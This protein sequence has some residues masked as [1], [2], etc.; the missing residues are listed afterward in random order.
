MKTKKPIWAEI[1]NE[2]QDSHIR[3]IDAYLT[4]DEGEKGMY[5]K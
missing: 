2:F 3:H 5:N 1:R 4:D